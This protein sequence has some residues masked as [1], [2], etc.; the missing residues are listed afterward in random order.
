VRNSNQVNLG[1]N[2]LSILDL[3]EASNQPFIHDDLAL[4]YN[5]EIYNYLELREELQSLGHQFKTTGDTEVI[6]ASFKAW[7]LSCVK[8]FVGMWAFAIW[9]QQKQT[10]FCSRDPFGIKPFYYQIDSGRMYFASEYKALQRS[11]LHQSK[12]NERQIARYLQLGW[13]AHEDETFFANMHAL[14][15]GH[16]LVFK[17]GKLQLER[18]HDFPAQTQSGISDEEAIQG[19][20]DRFLQSLKIH[21]RSD[22]EV[23]GCLSGGLDSSAIA[24]GVGK[25]Y[26]DVNFK[27]F[28]IYY[29]GKNEVDERPFARLNHKKYPSLQG[30]EYE[31]KDGELEDHF[32]KFL[33]IQDV[34]VAGS[35]PFS[36]YFVMK[37]AAEHGVKVVLDGQGADEYLAGYMHAFYRAHAGQ[38]SR[39]PFMA[40]KE[41][42][43]HNKLQ[44]YGAREKVKRFLKTVLTATKSEQALYALEFKNYLPFVL[45]STETPFNLNFNDG[46][47]L[48]KFLHHQLYTASLPTLLHYEDRN[49]MAFSIESRVPFLDHRLVNYTMSLPDSFKIRDGISKFILRKGLSDLLPEEITNR[50]D[51]KG[52]VTP[53]EVR[54]L[55]G[56]LKHFTNVNFEDYS[57]INSG[58][59]KQVIDQYNQGNNKAAKLVWRLAV[60]NRWL[61][62]NV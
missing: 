36:Q 23:G 43:S 6:L 17:D 24:S 46:S 38:F 34:P 27:T 35:S 52:F 3:S 4:T 60:L 41:L 10:L 8:R 14:P 25:L 53:G 51:K 57:I 15:A 62:K 29:S 16:N 19:F 30:F 21:M 39:N 2:R 37:L 54:W 5:G 44:N 11:P 22:V 40:M 18:Y 26:P 56:P 55:R 61:K 7:G 45:S 42:N 33:D 47:R 48:N 32:D 9:D 31:P 13:I 12:I 20:K 59:V 1:H 50:M 49:S 28:T 58:R